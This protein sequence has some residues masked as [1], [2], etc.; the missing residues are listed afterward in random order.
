MQEIQSVADSSPDWDSVS[1]LLDEAISALNEP[2]REALL[3]R[4]FKNQDFR[5]VGAALGVSDDTAQKCVARSLEKLARRASA[6]RC[7]HHDCGVV[8]RPC[9][10]C[11]AS[12][13][14]WFGGGRG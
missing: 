11:R 3:L 5:A 7:H 6:A 13:P 4:F 9:V 12:G 1:P 14:G 10:P 2:E 8:R